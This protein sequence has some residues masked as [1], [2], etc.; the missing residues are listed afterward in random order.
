[1]QLRTYQQQYEQLK[2]TFEREQARM[3][4]SAKSRRREKELQAQVGWE[5]IWLYHKLAIYIE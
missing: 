1:M 3:E 2:A 5:S 4:S